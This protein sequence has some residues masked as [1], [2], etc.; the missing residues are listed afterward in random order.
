[1]IGLSL[2]FWRTLLGNAAL[3]LMMFLSGDLSDPREISRPAAKS[4]GL[5]ND[6][7]ERDIQFLADGGFALVQ[8]DF[9]RGWMKKT[10]NL[11]VIL[12]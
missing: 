10:G 8:D 7:S 2:G 4:A 3:Q 12:G 5:R 11:G 9:R 6:A 1:M